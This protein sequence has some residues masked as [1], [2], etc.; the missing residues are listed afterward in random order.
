MTVQPTAVPSLPLVRQTQIPEVWCNALTRED[1]GAMTSTPLNCL[2]PDVHT[3][4]LLSS[5]RRRYWGSVC[6]VNAGTDRRHVTQLTRQNRLFLDL[7]LPFAFLSHVKHDAQRSPVI[8]NLTFQLKTEKL[9]TFFW[10]YLSAQVYLF[11]WCRRKVPVHYASVR[12]G[13]LEDDSTFLAR[14]HG[15][16]VF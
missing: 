8:F 9:G 14:V 13:Q 12:S 5:V 2:Q 16:I 3:L 6:G 1:C 10:R 7:L 4:G 15:L 11:H